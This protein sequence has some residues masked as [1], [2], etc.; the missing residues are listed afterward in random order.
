MTVTWQTIEATLTDRFAARRRW[1]HGNNR[2]WSVP[3]PLYTAG[4]LTVEVTLRPRWCSLAVDRWHTSNR[5]PDIARPWLEANVWPYVHEAC[6]R[7]R[8]GY[9]TLP[10][11]GP[12]FSSAHPIDRA[13]L[14]DVLV[15]WVEAELTWH[16]PI[17]RMAAGPTRWLQPVGLSLRSKPIPP[18]WIPRRASVK[19]GHFQSFSH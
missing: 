7:R 3:T 6:N 1:R 4:Y 16:H 17:D 5:D 18:W 11:G 8:S 19:S 2:G 12:T 15:P 14:L 9:G 10:S 13:V